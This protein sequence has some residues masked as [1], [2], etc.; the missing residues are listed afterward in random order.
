[1]DSTRRRR[2]RRTRSHH[3]LE[4]KRVLYHPSDDVEIPDHCAESVIEIPRFLTS[5]LGRGGIDAELSGPLRT[6]RA[7]CRKFMDTLQVESDRS[8]L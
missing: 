5:V 6:M 3:Q 1:M 7:A 8:R 4:V 2:G